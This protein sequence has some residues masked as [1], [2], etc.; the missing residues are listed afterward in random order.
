MVASELISDIIPTVKPADTVEKVFLLFTEFRVNE[1]PVVDENHFLGLIAEDDLIEITDEQ[2]VVNS[3]SILK[4]H[5]F[6]RQNQHIY[7]V[8]RAFH[9]NQLS[10]L[11]V[12]DMENNYIGLINIQRLID[13][14]AS[15]TAVAEPG[16]I[17][18]LEIS[19]RDNSLAQMAQI[20]ESDQA[21]ILS[22]YTTT[23]P[24]ATQM[25]VTLKINKRDIS[26]IVS[27][28]TRYNY[29]VKEVYNQAL[30]E[31]DS[32]NRYDLLMNYLNF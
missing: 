28:F 15:L 16:A 27:G 19:N 12:L 11:P 24:G 21:Q 13:Y 29:T 30:V 2:L 14:F 25:E 5:A 8:I 3:L 23:F 9:A 32:M 17:I 7:D 4:K 6:V 20:V 26:S 18:V 22:S 1:L 31:D 10:V